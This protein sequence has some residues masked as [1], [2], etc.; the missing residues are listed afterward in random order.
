[1]QRPKNL[2][3]DDIHKI[4]SNI[5]EEYSGDEGN[6]GVSGDAQ[7]STAQSHVTDNETNQ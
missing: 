6:E 2:F 1:M 3:R 5:N 4:L 7:D